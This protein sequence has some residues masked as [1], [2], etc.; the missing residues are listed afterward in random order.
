MT[1]QRGKSTACQTHQHHNYENM[2][3]YA[4]LKKKD[5]TKNIEKRKIYHMIIVHTNIYVDKNIKC[6]RKQRAKLLT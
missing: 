6:E 5:C 2:Y 3:V 1:S 4:C